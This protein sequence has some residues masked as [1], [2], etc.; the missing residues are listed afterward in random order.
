LAVSD[1]FWQ[2]WAGH[3]QGCIVGQ[4]LW[5]LA[6]KTA[7][8]NPVVA[9][10]QEQILANQ[11]RQY[12]VL[13]ASAAARDEATRKEFREK[14]VGPVPCRGGF[15]AQ[16]FYLDFVFAA[17]EFQELGGKDNI[18]AVVKNIADI[19]KQ[20]KASSMLSNEYLDE[21]SLQSG[22]ASELF[23]LAIDLLGPKEKNEHCLRVTHQ[24]PLISNTKC[25][26][27]A[28][29]GIIQADSGTR[30]PLTQS[31]DKIDICVWFVHPDESLGACVLAAIEY[32]PDTRGEEI[33]KVQADMYAS[34]IAVLHQKP[35]VIVDIAG[36]K[37]VDQWEISASGFVEVEFSN[38]SNLYETTPLFSGIG[39]EAIVLVAHGLLQAQ[40]SFPDRLKDYGMRLGPVVRLIDGTVYKAYDDPR[41]RRPNFDVVN[42]LLDDKAE[43][44]HS[45]DHKLSILK[46]AAFP[47]DWK[48]VVVSKV[49]ELI[50]QK[51]LELHD[52]H[53]V[54]GDIRLANLLSCGKIVDFDFVG[55]SHYLETLQSLHQDGHRHPDVEEWI[56]TRE[57]DQSK[58]VPHECHDWYS[59]G[60]VMKL[61]VAVDK[62]NKE[63]WEM[64]CS[65]IEEN[66][67][68]LSHKIV[69]FEE[70]GIKL[71]DPTIPLIGTGHRPER[72]H[73]VEVNKRQKR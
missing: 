29:C 68:H 46:M 16:Q 24:Q 38:A 63:K 32:K 23:C 19:L 40:K 15:V 67:K 57:Q 8:D 45:K 39:V 13:G 28:S 6:V 49:F 9:M 64:Y 58:L 73:E 69:Q 17:Q 27:N 7:K 1:E 2:G 18:T 11:K 10:L 55:A 36:G 12:L 42:S 35:C 56:K 5:G 47:S 34:N 51:M 65:N 59:L 26:A 37:D 30:K 3:L 14:Q 4:G 60:Q 21:E 50:I 25:I 66:G 31:G 43:I 53:G 33:R 52:K 41:V 70:F 48:Q 20:R 22:V 71:V 61:F 54:H 62:S 72:L 44:F